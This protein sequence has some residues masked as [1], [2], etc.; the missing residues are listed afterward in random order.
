MKFGATLSTSAHMAVIAWAV[1][2]LSGPAP[3]VTMQEQGM[4]VDMAALSP[5]PEGAQG[6]PK[7]VFD[8]KPNPLPTKRPEEIPDAKNVGEANEDGQSRRGVVTDKPLD[9]VKTSA[10]PQAERVQTAPDVKPE[11]VS[12]PEVKETPVP[13]TEVA[14]LN[15]PKV[16]LEAEPE[17]DA[18]APPA[19]SE[20]PF[21]LPSIVPV[22]TS[23]PREQP[24]PK[25]PTT[26]DRKPAE[27]AKPVKTAAS[28]EKQK[29][30]TDRI[31]ALLNRQEDTASGARRVA[32]AEPSIGTPDAK[33]GSALTQ[34]EYGALKGRVGQ[35]WSIPT[36]VD[37][38]NL[39]IVVTMRMSPD[40]FMD[41]IVDMDVQGVD[42]PAHAQAVE[43][44]LQRNLDRRNCNFADV[45][46]AEKYDT[47][48][49][50]R[51]NFSP[52]EF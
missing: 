4:E 28:T 17:S 34:A 16:P 12:E 50:V 32:S 20:R 39:H 41:R 14:T 27:E 10:A 36:Y 15:E 52:S 5:D 8:R 43:S 25:S 22:P 45:L 19:E 1:L 13:T 11:P 24:K 31:G 6:Q 40:G 23:A 3:L 2:S 48:K 18:S 37:Q 47:W 9:T 26:Q 30:V 51:V 46:P 42:N 35:C 7:A 33:P 29:D 44:S 38:E 21:E 49:D